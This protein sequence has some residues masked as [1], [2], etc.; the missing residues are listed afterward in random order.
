VVAID[1][2]RNERNIKSVNNLNCSQDG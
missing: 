2:V 1:V